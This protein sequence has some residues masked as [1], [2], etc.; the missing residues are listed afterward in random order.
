MKCSL[1]ILAVSFM[2][3]CAVITD[4]KG[5]WGR[6]EPAKM[7]GGYSF[8]VRNVRVATCDLEI[9]RDGEAGELL[10]LLSGYRFTVPLCGAWRLPD[11]GVA[12]VVCERSGHVA[13]VTFHVFVENSPDNGLR[14][15]DSV[16]THLGGRLEDV[17][18]DGLMELVT[19]DSS[20]SL[21]G[22]WAHQLSPAPKV[23]L[24]F[25]PN[26]RRYLLAP[27]LMARPAL[28]QAAFDGLVEK[29]RADGPW[30]TA[31]GPDGFY[32]AVLGL[33]YGGNRDQAWRL[34]DLAW[35][36]PMEEKAGTA[37]ALRMCLRRS[38]YWPSLGFGGE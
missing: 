5:P 10:F 19:W 16:R 25:N 29:A 31:T 11:G 18:E 4:D 9:R 1:A 33:L 36:G 8:R 34:F 13:P 37:D 3:G 21:L 38:P 22:G 23:I 7:I 26:L 35:N 2:C 15:A 27:D 6:D 12:I 32:R 20:Y 17:D 14:L 28:D 30:R 24:R